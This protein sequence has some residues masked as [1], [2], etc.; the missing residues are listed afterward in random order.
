MNT[1]T[2]VQTLKKLNT[3]TTKVNYPNVWQNYSTLT[4]ARQPHVLNTLAARSF[5]FN[6]RMAKLSKPVDRTEWSMT[7]QTNNTY[8]EPTLNEICLPTDILQAPFF[9]EKADDAS[10]YKTLASTIDHE[11][12]HPIVTGKQYISRDRKS[13]RLNSS[14]E[15]PSRMPSSA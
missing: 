10:N 5:E 8:Y 4:I 14:H 7:P 3:M 9:D 1:K 12:L 2:K 11:I 6:H 15:I 13:T